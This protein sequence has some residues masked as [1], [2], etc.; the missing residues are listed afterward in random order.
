MVTNTAAT[1]KA[2][3]TQSVQVMVGNKMVQPDYAGLF[4]GGTPGFY[5]VP[6]KFRWMQRWGIKQ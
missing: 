2:P 1:A 4:V 3:T 5:Q 6:S